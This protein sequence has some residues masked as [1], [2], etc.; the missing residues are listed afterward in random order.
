MTIL[1]EAGTLTKKEGGR[2]KIGVITPG[3]GSSGTYPKETIEAAGR[4]KVFAAGTHMYLDHAT[5]AQDWERPEGSLRDLVGVLT[6]DA[7][8][9]DDAGGLIAEARIY[10]HWK[11]VLEEMKDDIGVSIRASGE[12][13][14]DAGK[15][16]VTRL[17][18]ARS[19][20]FVTRA[21]RGGRI[22]EVIESA[23]VREASTQETRE[24]LQDALK[25]QH[26]GEKQY[27]WVRDFDTDSHVVW[28]D[29]ESPTGSGTYEQ[30]YT[31]NGTD[32][33]LAGQPTEVVPTTKYVPK[34]TPAPAG[35]GNQESD[36]KEASEMGD[37]RNTDTS[38][39]DEADSKKPN[40]FAKGNDSGSGGGNGNETEVE[41][42]RRE[43]GE[44]KAEIKRLKA[45]GAKEARRLEVANIVEEAFENIDA[46]A[47]KD[48][49]IESFT[50]SE[51]DTEQIVK[52]AKTFADELTFAPNATGS[53]RGLGES[54]P[55]VT[56][57]DDTPLTYDDLVALK[58]A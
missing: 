57:S 39:V 36:N 18:E 37:T 28:F 22:L 9:D 40:P 1:K 44:L 54:R 20:D 27:V 26:G 24:L 52:E 17:T 35:N 56:E 51:K 55:V 38:R 49:L 13:R 19:V 34:T 32:I 42:L 30:T 58:G 47:T 23:R 43:N 33:A 48:A 31:A 4:D 41:K 10:S 53:V 11:P 46:P 12:V 21:G 8:W 25:S 3:T 15:R 50:S 14:E 29:L 6:E 45:Q 5:E 16:I 7:H 2:F